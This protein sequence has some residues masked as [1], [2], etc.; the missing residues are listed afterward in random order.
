MGV[1][2]G[3]LIQGEFIVM[4]YGPIFDKLTFLGGAY[5]RG[6]AIT[7][8]YGMISLCDS[9]NVGSRVAFQVLF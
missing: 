4:F 8:F 2:A 9:L 7:D 6:G 1:S 5:L 3:R